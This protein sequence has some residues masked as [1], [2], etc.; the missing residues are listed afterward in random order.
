MSDVAQKDR[1]I[2]VLLRA[3]SVCRGMLYS[4]RTGDA[5]RDEIE[6]IL[7][8]T[9]ETQL[10]A[11]LGDAD[12]QSAVSLSEALPN[13]DRNRLLG[14]LPLTYRDTAYCFAA[15]LVDGNTAA[16]H[17]LLSP[18]LQAQYAPA[19][20][21]VH[22]AQMIA[23]TGQDA[24][25]ASVSVDTTM[26]DWADKQDDDWGWAYVSIYRDAPTGSFAEAVTVIVTKDGHI[27]DLVWGRP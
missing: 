15:H 20:L 3:V 11:M 5:S 4:A 24:A 22:L 23:Y 16:A 19:D 27:R 1:T 9:S 17:A 7:E 10:I 2:A 26:D 13:A 18:S 14:I 21:Q 8:S 6:R 12:Y 25:D